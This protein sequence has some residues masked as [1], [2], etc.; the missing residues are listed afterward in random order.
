[1]QEDWDEDIFEECAVD[2]TVWKGR[3]GE[4]YKL[5]D[6]ATS[7]INNCL[8]LIITGKFNAEWTEQKAEQW[9]RAFCQELTNRRKLSCT[10]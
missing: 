8:R 7:H 10:K 3:D 4:T 2:T 1:M 5:E 9:D 6:M